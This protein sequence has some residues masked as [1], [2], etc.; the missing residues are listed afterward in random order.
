MWPPWRSACWLWQRAPLLQYAQLVSLLLPARCLAACLPVCACCHRRR[1]HTAAAAAAPWLPH[2]L[3]HTPT[4][5]PHPPPRLPALPA[6]YL[7]LDLVD[8]TGLASDPLAKCL[9]SVKVNLADDCSVSLTPLSSGGSY[10]PGIW[11]DYTGVATYTVL[12]ECPVTTGAAVD[13]GD[14]PT[15][16]VAAMETAFEN[17]VYGSG[18]PI[19]AT[20][21]FSAAGVVTVTIGAT[22][23][24]YAITK[25]R[26]ATWR[27][28]QCC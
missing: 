19:A 4:H 8:A 15:D 16:Q 27:C 23:L 14:Q 28:C 25:V 24:T 20:L 18:K 12:R 9:A 2:R 10:V 26:A 6:G 13:G 17:F 1:H 22:P 3:P 7:Q 5:P 11:A 21:A